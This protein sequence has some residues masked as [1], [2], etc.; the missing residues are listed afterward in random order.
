MALC[1]VACLMP[2]V[3][4]GERVI[5]LVSWGYLT[6]LCKESTSCLGFGRV[7]G[8]GLC[9]GLGLFLGFWLL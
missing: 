7:C 6:S 1:C 2:M 5:G 9:G 4:R 3:G 8:A